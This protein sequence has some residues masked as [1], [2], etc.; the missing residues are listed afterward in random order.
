MPLGTAEMTKAPMCVPLAGVDSPLWPMPSDN[1][2]LPHFS[3]V[4]KPSFRYTIPVAPVQTDDDN[5]AA[6]SLTR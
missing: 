6:A 1:P 4:A 3:L 2:A 5:E